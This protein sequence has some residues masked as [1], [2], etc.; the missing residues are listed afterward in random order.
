MRDC[1]I[2]ITLLRDE[3]GLSE[4][5]S[6]RLT[7]MQYADWQFDDEDIVYLVRMDCRD[8]LRFHDSNRITFHALKNF[9][10]II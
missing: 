3:S 9:R 1:R 10:N 5:D 4:E 8:A 7:G 2:V 6:I